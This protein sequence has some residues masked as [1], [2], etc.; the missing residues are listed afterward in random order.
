MKS[1]G[2]ACR[3]MECE[4]KFHVR[5]GFGSASTAAAAEY[6]ASL[7]AA[8][9]GAVAKFYNTGPDPETAIDRLS[10][11]TTGVLTRHVDRGT[12]L[13]SAKSRRETEDGASRA[14]L[15]TSSGERK[16]RRPVWPKALFS[17]SPSPRRTQRLPDSCGVASIRADDDT[18]EAIAVEGDQAQSITS[19]F[20]KRV[21]RVTTTRTSI[22]GAGGKS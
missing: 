7:A 21:R 3:N 9:V 14:G 10:I 22:A 15:R 1:V 4:N 6:P 19:R 13:A 16:T 12:T 5:L 17:R 20:G 2:E 8:Y 11:S 18:G